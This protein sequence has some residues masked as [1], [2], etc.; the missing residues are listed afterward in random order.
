MKP[1]RWV[2]SH[3]PQVSASQRPSIELSSKERA[4]LRVNLSG[5]CAASMASLRLPTAS[6][7]NES[8]P[9]RGVADLYDDVADGIFRRLALAVHTSNPMSRI[10]AR[11]SLAYPVAYLNRRNT[12]ASCPHFS[13]SSA[14]S[15]ISNSSLSCRDVLRSSTF[16]P[17]GTADINSLS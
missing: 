17:F 14:A 16:K 12:C 10:Q 5:A 4:N 1:L 7:H 11:I 9:P 2:R 8:P 3:L 13:T 15:A 6:L